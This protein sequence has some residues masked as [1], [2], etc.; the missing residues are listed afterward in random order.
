MNSAAQL[1]TT[2]RGRRSLPCPRLLHHLRWA[3]LRPQGDNPYCL[4][5]VAGANKELLVSLGLSDTLLDDLGQAVSQFEEAMASG[6]GGRVAHIRARTIERSR[7]ERGRR[8]AGRVAKRHVRRHRGAHR[9]A[10]QVGPGNLEMVQQA[11]HVVGHRVAVAGR[12]AELGAYSHLYKIPTTGLRF[13]TVYGPWGR[14]DMALFLFTRNILEGQPVH[15]FNYGRHLRDFTYI[16]DVVEAV[17][18]VLDNPAQSDPEWSGLTPDPAKSSAP[19]RIY[20]YWK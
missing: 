7:Q 20:K 17:V 15:V 10:H 12:V 2:T 13:F 1:A 3:G 11:D 19:Y 9:V 6:H 14:P 18:H 5:G 4:L 16:D 8:G